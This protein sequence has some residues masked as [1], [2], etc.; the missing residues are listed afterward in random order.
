MIGFLHAF[1]PGPRSTPRRNLCGHAQPGRYC[2]RSCPVDEEALEHSSTA[3]RV[4]G[5][6]E[7]NLGR[8]TCLSQEGP[9]EELQMR[10]KGV[11]GVVVG[12]AMPSLLPVISAVDK[13]C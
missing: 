3:G 8:E 9:S 6:L 5:R 7:N 4:G 1:Q 10:R 12:L 13:A 11:G 2:Q